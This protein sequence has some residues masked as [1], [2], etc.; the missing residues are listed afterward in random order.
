MAEAVYAL[1]ALTSIAIAV[2]LFRGYA[3]S[4]ARFLMWSGLCF[5]G[6]AINNA[7]LFVDD[8]VYAEITNLSFLGVSMRVWRSISALVGLALL[9]WGLIFDA[10]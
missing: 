4:G 5:V 10:D 2:L 9:L 1:C 8:V 7:L 3:R 6:L